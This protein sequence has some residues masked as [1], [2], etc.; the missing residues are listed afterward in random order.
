M[1]AAVDDTARGVLSALRGNTAEAVAAFSNALSF[2]YLRLDRANLQA[3]YATVVG[4]NVAEAR[5]A[6]DEAYEVLSA[7]GAAGFLQLYSAGMP[8]PEERLAA[9]S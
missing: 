7:A 3:L 2:R 9:G 8:P 1:L 4:R 5:K 6:S